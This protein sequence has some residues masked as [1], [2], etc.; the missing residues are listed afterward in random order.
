M[1][2]TTSS[3]TLLVALV[4][5]ACVG[6][7]SVERVHDPSRPVQEGQDWVVYSSGSEGAALKR[8]LVD[9]EGGRT[10]EGGELE[11]DSLAPDW[12]ASVQTENPTG[13]FDA[14]AVSPDGQLLAFT[15]FDEGDFGIR[16]V[17]GVAHRDGAAWEPGGV[18][19]RSEGES[20]GTPRAMDPA[21]IMDGDAL[22]LVFGSHAGGIYL[23]ELDSSS[24]QLLDDPDLPETQERTERFRAIADDPEDG[25][26]AATLHARGGAFYLFVNKGACCRGLDSTY[27]VEVGRAQTIE[28]PYLDRDGLSLLDSGGTTFLEDEGDL[29]GPG[30]VGFMDLGEG[31]EVVTFHFYD[32][33]AKGRADLGA[34]EVTWDDEGWPT[35]GE[36][37]L[38]RLTP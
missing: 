2:R 24:G 30:H 9:L 11:A 32:A 27:R 28:G 19:V 25:I 6:G 7:S 33:T 15:V 20:A 35:A 26:E 14:P 37:L 31:E 18:V 34:R 12:W 4:C 29:V 22:W 38:P 17:I 8:T 21:F 23:T 10:R 36:V 1:T 3:L 5:P 16:D 13:E